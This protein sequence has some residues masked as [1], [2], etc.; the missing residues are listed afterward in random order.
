MSFIQFVCIK[1]YYYILVFWVLEISFSV[2][3]NIFNSE[4]KPAST[5]EFINLICLNISDLLAGFLVIYTFC[6][7][8]EQSN[9]KQIKKSNS[10]LIFNDPK[11]KKYKNILLVFISILD[12]ISRSVYF[13]FCVLIKIDKPLDRHQMDLIVCI[14]ILFRYIFSIII[15]KTNFYKHHLF[16]IIITLIGFLFMTVLD[17]ISIFNSDNEI[18]YNLY[19]ISFVLVRAIFFPL[20]DTINKILL[21]N[22]FLLPHSL[23]FS[24]GFIQFLI[25][26]LIYIPSLKLTGNLTIDS[27]TT[28]IFYYVFMKIIYTIVSSIKAF[29]LMNVIY[30]FSSQYVSFI[31]VSESVGGT[32]NLF[33][34]Q[35]K[36]GTEEKIIM[37]LLEIIPL[38]F[39]IFGSLIYNEIIIIHK[40][41]LEEKT[42]SNLLIME[43][44]E[45]NENNIIN[46]EKEN[47]NKD[48]NDDKDDKDN[49]LLE[50]EGQ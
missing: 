11:K 20:A 6:S 2:I 46:D 4:I 30:S 23:M 27:Y 37:T 25:I 22:D 9:K 44:I 42:N 10:K 28:S 13:L 32:I 50:M 38:L 19:Y 35:F 7:I 12:L 47:D 14:D 3:D 34:K 16:A 29:C 15:L 43:K 39:I 36:N 24:R 21:S 1:K 41:G 8:R 40:F 45:S 26:I 33:I 48:I 17:F 31:V 18:S 5:N 49:H